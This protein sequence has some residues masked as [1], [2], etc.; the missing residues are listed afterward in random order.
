MAVTRKVR[1]MN[2]DGTIV[3]ADIGALAENVKEDAQR[4]FVSDTEKEK[5]NGHVAA[6]GGDISETN[7][8][9]E[10][11][12][13]DTK[14][15]AMPTGAKKSKTTGGIFKR[16]LESLK[17]DKV[18]VSGGDISDTKIASVTTSTASYPVPAA[19]DTG[20]VFL[21]KIVKFFDDIRNAA[22]GA[23]FIGQIVNNCVSTDTNKPLS[24]AQGKYLMDLYTGL[25][26]KTMIYGAGA[27][28]ANNHTIALTDTIYT[29]PLEILDDNSFLSLDHGILTVKKTG[30]YFVRFNP[31]VLETNTFANYH[32]FRIYINE[33]LATI[34]TNNNPGSTV[35]NYNS[36]VLSD[37]VYL[38]TGTKIS[39]RCL[40]GQ[41][42][43]VTNS[44]I[45]IV[46]MQTCENN[47]LN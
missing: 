23:C 12:A 24:A 5:W 3:E 17:T 35:G 31:V 19:G 10:E 8:T 39:V 43:T 44:H 36:Y 20:K 6:D 45:R 38:T 15:P 18:D 41:P 30:W 29:I 42:C 2:E 37:F 22:T 4:R 16:W 27:N 46:L 1:H 7:I 32:D 33:D 9:L 11:Q 34:A 47:I 28:I 40:L 21:G 13:A 25:N 14:Y 26:T